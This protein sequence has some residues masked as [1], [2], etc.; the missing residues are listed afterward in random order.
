MRPV[1]FNLV[2]CALSFFGKLP[3]WV[4]KSIQKE[5]LHN[6]L[7][8]VLIN[9]QYIC[10]KVSF[11][12]NPYVTVAQSRSCSESVVITKSKKYNVITLWLRKIVVLFLCNTQCCFH[13]RKTLFLTTTNK[14]KPKV[15]PVIESSGQECPAVVLTIR[16]KSRFYGE[17]TK[18]AWTFDQNFENFFLWIIFLSWFYLCCLWHDASFVCNSYKM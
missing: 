1:I 6:F 10:H 2:C 3:T 11:K 12:C 13:F 14:T 8:C 5:Q 17:I 15:S 7:Y 4:K 16:P 18:P 9:R